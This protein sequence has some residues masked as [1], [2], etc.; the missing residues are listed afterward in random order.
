MCNFVVSFF[1][2]LDFLIDTFLRI[3][4]TALFN[5]EGTLL[6]R[7][8]NRRVQ[9]NDPSAD[10]ETDAFRRAGRQTTCRNR[11]MVTTLAPCLYCTGLVLQFR[12]GAVVVGESVNFSGGLDWL[13]QNEVKVMDLRSDRC[14]K[15]LSTY[16]EQSSNLE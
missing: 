3:E 5:D 16:R 4:F 8:H 2:L 15:L 14:V 1:L 12:I 11:I 9:A 13:R 7:G 6:G 10:G